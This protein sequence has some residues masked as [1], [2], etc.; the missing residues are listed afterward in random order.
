[1]NL[2]KLLGG[3]ME[4]LESQLRQKLAS[5]VWTHKIQ[6]KQADYYKRIYSIME[7]IRIIFYAIIT[8]GTI[9]SIFVDKIYVKVITAI[10]SMGTVFI[11]TYFKLKDLKG[12]HQKYKEA[13][14]QLLNLRQEIIS[15]LCDIK[16]RKINEGNNQR[17]KEMK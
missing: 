13:A 12:L 17:I 4:Y 14:I 5:V 9:S 16:W 6:Q 2:Y 8:S 3:I 1:M 10:I 7:T 11:S 15:I